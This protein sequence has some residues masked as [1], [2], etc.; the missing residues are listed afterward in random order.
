MSRAILLLHWTLIGLLLGE[1]V[2]ATIQVFIVTQ[3]AGHV[4]PMF[5]LANTLPFE[6]MVVRRLYAVEAW[7]A[8][9][10]LSLYLGVTEILPRRLRHDTG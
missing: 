10:A 2:Y 7:I 6:Q 1:A 9:A 8:I 3:P 4:G 5:G